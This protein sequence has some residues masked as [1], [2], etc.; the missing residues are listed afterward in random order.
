MAMLNNC[1]SELRLAKPGPVR[2][3]AR[4]AAL[5]GET[6]DDSIRKK[7]YDQKPYW[8][9]ERSRIGDTNPPTLTDRV[10][11]NARVRANNIAIRGHYFTAARQTLGF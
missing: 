10:V 11:M 2:V 8:E 4:V 6:P 3:N 1:A 9:L 7:P 5:L